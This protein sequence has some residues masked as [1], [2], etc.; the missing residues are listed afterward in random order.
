MIHFAGATIVWWLGV[1]APLLFAMSKFNGGERLC[2]I[3]L[4]MLAL[5]MIPYGLYYLAWAGS[6]LPRHGVSEVLTLDDRWDR[7]FWSQTS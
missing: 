6:S 1:C 7:K 4:C 3:I 5:V 2:G